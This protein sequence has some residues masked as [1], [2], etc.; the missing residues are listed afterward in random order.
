MQ[1]DLNVMPG[2]ADS[3]TRSRRDITDELAG[4]IVDHMRSHALAVGTHL[5]AQE[6]ADLFNVSRS[7]VTQALRLL[8]DKQIVAHMPNKGFYALLTEPPALEDL[9]LATPARS[10]EVYFRV[11]EDRVRGV[12]PDQVSERSL[13]QRYDLTR[14][15]ANELL[16]RIAEEGWATRRPGYGWQFAPVLTTPESLEQSYRLRIAIEPEALLEPTFDLPRRL[17]QR[18]HDREAD[19][20][21]GSIETM[22][23]DRLY[24]SG[25][26]FH[27]MLATASRN[28]FFLDTLKR[29]N[30]MRRLFAYRA[31][32]DRRRY[33]GQVEEHMRILDLLIE[34]R[35][36]DAARSMRIHLET[37]LINIRKIKPGE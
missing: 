22:S 20:L 30:R 26:A 17:A 31:M 12:L 27:E 13:R 19:M 28:P 21:R 8:A 36:A 2:S 1:P 4:R 18:A 23:P 14:G 35:N 34:G 5:P 25:V 15:E 37:V 11:A 33:Y 3:T 6:L 32:V 9:G 16:N 10:R 24:E 29:V 7:P